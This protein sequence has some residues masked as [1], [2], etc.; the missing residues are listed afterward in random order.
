MRCSSSL[1][2]LVLLSL[3]GFALAQVDPRIASLSK[4]LGTGQEPK[5]RSQA[6]LGLGSSDDPEALKPLCAALKDSSEQVRAASAQALG[7]LKELAGLEC[8]KSRKSETDAATKAAIQ[9][10]IEALQA[11]KERTPRVYVQLS[12]VKDKTGQLK[13]EVLKVTEARMRRKLTQVGAMLAPT[14]ESKA[15]AQGVLRKHG[16]QGFRLQAEIHPTEGG[17]LRV[18]VVCISYPD[19]ALLGD[20]ELQASGAKPEE[21]LKVLA[22]RIIDEAADT[23]EWDT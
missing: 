22:P 9:A 10:S 17:G 15:A 4:Q 23:F 19:Q 16:I 11:F 1:L 13:P 12:G 2:A 14:K 21:L 5:V 6:A 7:K 3:P 8:L 18:S 20:V